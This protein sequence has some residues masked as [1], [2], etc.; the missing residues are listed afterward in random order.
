MSIE[1][2]AF[3]NS[4]VNRLNLFSVFCSNLIVKTATMYPLDTQTTD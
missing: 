2:K 3:Q 4:R 1:Q